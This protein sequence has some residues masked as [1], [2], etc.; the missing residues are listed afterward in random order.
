MFDFLLTVLSSLDHVSSVPKISFQSCQSI[1][2]L[3]SIGGLY[4][5]A[6]LISVLSARDLGQI[7]LFHHLLT[8]KLMGSKIH[9]YIVS[10]WKESFI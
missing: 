7:S 3:I 9:G 8:V 4:M 5:S 10:A 6:C 1:G 2:G